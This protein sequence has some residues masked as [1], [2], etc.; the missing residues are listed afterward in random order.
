ME[1]LGWGEITLRMIAQ[2]TPVWIALIATFALSIGFKRRLGLYGKL[3]DSIIGMIGFLLVTFW[4][5]TAIFASGV[6]V[7]SATLVPSIATFDP[8]A[9]ISAMKNKL[10]GTFVP[11][12]EAAFYL[13]GGDNLGRAVFSRMVVGSQGVMSIAPAARQI[14]CSYQYTW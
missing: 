4:L 1:P 14:T 8:L 5:F 11:D 12:S 10:P 9:Q 6:S 7:G 3:F 2:F 13:L